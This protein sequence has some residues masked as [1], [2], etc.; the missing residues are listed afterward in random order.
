MPDRPKGGKS[1]YDWNDALLDAQGHE[2]KLK[3]L[4]RAIEEAPTFDQVMTKE[5]KREVRL[6]ALAVLKLEDPLA[7]EADHPLAASRKCAKRS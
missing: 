6:N 2:A 4:A 1:G 3:E 7:Y 5:E